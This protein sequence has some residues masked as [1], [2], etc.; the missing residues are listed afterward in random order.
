M[1]RGCSAATRG[2]ARGGRVR[3]APICESVGRYLRVAVPMGVGAAPRPEREGDRAE[4][5]RDRPSAVER[6][7]CVRGQRLGDRHVETIS[8]THNRNGTL[9]DSPG[10]PRVL[11]PISTSETPGPDL[12]SSA[13]AIVGRGRSVSTSRTL[14]PNLAAAAARWRV[15]VVLPSP[16]A[17]GRT[18]YG[19]R[20]ASRAGSGAS[21][22]QH[23]CERINR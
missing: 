19:F 21:N 17:E 20:P 9:A 7:N 14:D 8:A 23:Q 12:M 3:G 4:R 22:Q 13:R 18:R 6:H 11:A 5:V 10:A 1:M 15:T 16:G 2:P